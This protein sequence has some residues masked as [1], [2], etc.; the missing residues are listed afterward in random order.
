[1]QTATIKA[2]VCK[3]A[4]SA[5]SIWPNG[6]GFTFRGWEYSYG[7]AG[8]ACWVARRETKAGANMIGRGETPVD[9][10]ANAYPHDAGAFKGYFDKEPWPVGFDGVTAGLM[11]GL[12]ILYKGKDQPGERVVVFKTR[13]GMAF[14]Q[15]ESGSAFWTNILNLDKW[16]K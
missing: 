4:P 8:G 14:V 16:S 10:K 5:K 11:R 15:D 7:N 12:A 13:R 3:H 1:M 9:A 6:L 2:E